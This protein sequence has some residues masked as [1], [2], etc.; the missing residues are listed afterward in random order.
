MKTTLLCSSLFLAALLASCGTA[1]TCDTKSCATGCCDSS[2]T[3]RSGVAQSA[4]GKGGA[5]CS[6]CGASQTCSSGVCSGGGTGGGSAGTG[7]G[8]TGT[9]GGT[10]GTGGGMTGTGGGTTSTGA[11]VNEICSR[12][13]NEYIELYNAGAAAK[14]LSGYGVCDTQSDGGPYASRA[15]VF[16]A[17]TT[18]PS[19]GFVLVLLGRTDAGS[20]TDCIDGGVTSCFE[21]TWSISNGNGETAWLLDGT[22]AVESSTVYPANGH[23]SGRSYG[24]IP[25]GTGAFADTA[26]TPGAPNAP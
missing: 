25:D 3:C 8:A 2:G 14:D 1:S 24:R 19:H 11:V 18:V 9:G 12:G 21:T 13:G 16:P 22:G 20:T 4:C 5:V 6:A 26:R 17:G 10:T 15:L 7:G 23:A